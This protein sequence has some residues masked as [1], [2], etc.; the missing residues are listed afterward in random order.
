MSIGFLCIYICL[1]NLICVV[2]N[3]VMSDDDMIKLGRAFA[4]L[5]AKPEY[6]PHELE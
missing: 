4:A 2:N 5:G 3:L 1:F 6:S